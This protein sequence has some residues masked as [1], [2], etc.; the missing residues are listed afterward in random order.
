MRRSI[1]LAAGCVI[2]VAAP[3]VAQGPL[4]D[5]SDEDCRIHLISSLT[6]ERVAIAGRWTNTRYYANYAN[7]SGPLLRIHP[8]LPI[9]LRLNFPPAQSYQD[10]L[11]PL[12]DRE[13]RGGWID[14]D[15]YRVNLKR[16]LD[17]LIRA[18]ARAV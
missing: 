16:P 4:C 18:A 7:V 3:A 11:V 10:R 6:N 9:D 8:T 15:M 1:I 12:I 17:A 14:V 2:T 13:P 5:T